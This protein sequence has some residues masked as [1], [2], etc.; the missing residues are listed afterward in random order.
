MHY[1]NA[2]LIN[3]TTIESPSGL[4]SINLYHG[5]ICVADDELLVISSHAGSDN[6]PT[7]MVVNSL[8]SNFAVDF[9]LLA[10]ILTLESVD[11]VG[12]Y[13]VQSVA[14]SKHPAKEILLVR[15]PGYDAA[16]RHTPDP[17]GFYAET[18]WTLFGTLAAFEQKGC[19]FSS[20]AMPILAGS[21]GYPEQEIMEVLLA[22]TAK[23]LKSSSS[24]NEVNFYL[25]EN[26]YL[27]VW[28]DAMNAALGRRMIDS[29][30]DN[31]VT[32]LRDE[33]VA[34]IKSSAKFK[35]SGIFDVIK[36]IE[37]A[38]QEK[39]ICLQ[40][41]STFSRKL[42]EYIVDQLMREK[43]LGSRGSL[44]NNITMLNYEQVVAPWIASHFHALRVF[45]NET[46]H[47]KGEVKYR[48]KSLKEDD[49]VAILTSLRSVLSFYA[50][51]E[52]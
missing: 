22:K 11:F 19:C 52:C 47:V 42:V 13:R 24:M 2:S 26:D 43:T 31:V 15:I 48:P 41:V 37:G 3:S 45:G 29:A 18:V 35:Q 5:D 50:D 23:W 33:I 25:F 8:T 1:Q 16:E 30:K 46:V 20:M 34:N 44:V 6:K 12:T 17:M 49:L 38:L 21:R 27:K 32:A 28:S 14:E 9:S 4:R 7:G 10:P 36:P 40:L 39:Q 51:W